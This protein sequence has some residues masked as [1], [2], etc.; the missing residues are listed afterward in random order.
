V[1]QRRRSVSRRT[2]V[3]LGLGLW[4]AF[5]ASAT[6]RASSAGVEWGVHLAPSSNGSTVA[7]SVVSSGAAWGYGL[8]PSDEILAVDGADPGDLSG[9]DVPAS[10]HEL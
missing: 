10:V 2:L 3:G 6:F 1:T 8:R 4:V 9:R 7:A 5:L